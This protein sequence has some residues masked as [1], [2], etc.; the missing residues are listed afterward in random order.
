MGNMHD[1]SI[2]F[3]DNIQYIFHKNIVEYDMNAASVSVCERFKLLTDSEIEKLKLMPKDQRTRWMGLKQRD[4][5]FSQQLL[6][7]IREIRRK[8]IE[9]NGLSEYNIL[10]L[11]SDAIDFIRTKEVITKIEGVTFKQSFECN[12]YIRYH[13]IEIFY[14]DGVIKYK[15]IPRDILNQHTL[16]L[17]KHIMAFCDR[18]DN[19]D[20]DILRFISKFQRQYLQD[21]LPEYYYIPF[22]TTGVFKMENLQLLA[23]FANIA[24]QEVKSWR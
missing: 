8:F 1:K 19:Y 12:S 4:K 23:Y 22:G 11:H 7:G 14:Q 17:N 9:L 10:S 24:I 16:G 13:N 20:T 15:N 5:E 18:I 6:S 3:N 2:W 21:K